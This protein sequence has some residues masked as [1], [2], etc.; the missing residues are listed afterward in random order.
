M[1]GGRCADPT[2]IVTPSLFG[3]PFAGQPFAVVDLETTGASAIY[4]RIVEVAVVR[5]L[6][7]EIVERYEQLVDPRVPIPP[8]ITRLTGIDGRMVRGKPVFKDVATTVQASLADGPL[9][10]HNASFDEAFLRHAFTRAGQKLPLPKLCPLPLARRLLPRLPA[11]RLD[12]LSAY[13]GIKNGRRPRAA[14]DAEATARLLLRL[15]DIAAER[16]A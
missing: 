12:A 10:A 13:F 6:D 14:G 8:F 4:D 16:G 2:T 15:L 7:G 9:V 11:Y 1:A 5:L 3:T